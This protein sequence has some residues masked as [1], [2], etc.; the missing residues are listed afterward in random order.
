LQE[1]HRTAVL[2]LVAEVVAADN[3]DLRAA[4]IGAQLSGLLLSRYLLQVTA[5]AAADPEALIAAVAPA[6]DQYLTADLTG[7][8]PASG[9]A[10]T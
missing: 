4:L 10:D 9:C 7:A 2:A 6:I 5:L 1:L 3:R 8:S